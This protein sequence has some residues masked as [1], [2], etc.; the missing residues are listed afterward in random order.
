MAAVELRSI[1]KSFGS[2]PVLRNV[3]LT[4]ADGEFL[5]GW[6]VRLREVHLLR[7]IA[8]LELQDAGTVIIGGAP[9]DHLRPHE[10]RVAMVFQSYALY[11]HMSVFNNIALPLMMSKLSFGQRLP[12]VGRG[13]RAA[14][15]SCAR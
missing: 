5:A 1:A 4:I 2:V 11:P 12:L 3:D 13:R 7:V 14:R 15:R 8:G 6:T 10:R 9:V